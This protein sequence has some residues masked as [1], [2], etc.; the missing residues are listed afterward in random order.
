MTAKTTSFHLATALRAGMKGYSLKTLRS[1]AVA[2]LVVSLVALPLS[3]ALAIAVG[4]PPQHGLYTAIVAGV[5]A[6]LLGGSPTQVSGPTAAFVVIVA[7]IVTQYGLH[8]IIWCQIIA[9]IALIAMGVTRMGRLIHFVP[10]PVTTGFTAGIAVTIAALALNDFFGLGLKDL[11][12]HFIHKAITIFESLP[13]L[14]GAETAIGVSVLVAIFAV[15]RF[16]PRV[17]GAVAGITLGLVM[18]WL[19]KQNGIAVDTLFTRF[20]YLAPDGATMQGIPPYP[21]ALHLPGGGD[22]LFALPDMIEFRKLLMPSLVV[23]ALGALESLLSATVADSLARTRHDPDA[24][25]SGIGIANI[26]SGLAAG[27]PATGAIARTAANIQAGART[28]VASIIHALLILVYMMTLAPYISHIPMAALAALLLSVAWRMSHLHQFVRIVRLAPRSDIVVLVTCFLL[29]VFV[30]MVAGVSVG[31][32]MASLLFMARVADTTHL[33]VGTHHAPDI[34]HGTLPE[35][36]MVYR[37]EGP[38]FFGSIDK[39]IAGADAIGSDIRR[40][41]ID[42]MHVPMIDMTGMMGMKTFLMAVAQPGRDI[43]ICG[44]DDVTSRIR[45]KITDL[46]I[47][48][49]VH[50]TD[51][52]RDALK[53]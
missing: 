13:L 10:Y 45:R 37:I 15:P 23:A 31:M 12:G 16:F 51:S 5:V 11:S 7:P 6:A 2:G 1:D 38:L 26:F 48:K 32:V 44:H 50:M 18:A 8:G 3:M 53:H 40:L 20:S 19:F 14:K 30:D 41:V 46:P 4:L 47:A 17:P 21:P 42:L 43:T 36:V 35:G 25:L 39:M 9:G 34:A 27:I 22:A 52:V 49:H 33:H 24:E 28:P 29:T